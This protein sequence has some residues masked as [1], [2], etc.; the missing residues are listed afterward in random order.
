[1]ADQRLCPECGAPIQNWR[2]ATCGSDEC[3]TQRR[4]RQYRTAYRSMLDRREDKVRATQ[5]KRR[6]TDAFRKKHAA[7]EKKRRQKASAQDYITE[8]RQM[9]IEAMTEDDR[10]AARREARRRYAAMTD[11]ERAERN[12][13]MRVWRARRMAAIKADPVLHE[14]YLEDAREGRRRRRLEK[15]MREILDE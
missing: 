12:A 5:K 7:Y 9:R 2:M 11:D 1:M 10:D 4:R 15:M 14:K 13:K 3:R 6:S 8:Y